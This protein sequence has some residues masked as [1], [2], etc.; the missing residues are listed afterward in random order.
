MA[1]PMGNR[2]PLDVS[3]LTARLCR[4]PR[5]WSAVHVHDRISSTNAVA[6]Q[7]SGAW[8]VVVAEH[9]SAGRGRLDRSWEA[10]AGTSLTFSATVPAPARAPGWVPLVAGLA[11][12]EAI[13]AVT[14]LTALLKWPNDVLLPADDSRKVCGILCEYRPAADP[15][16]AIVVTGIGINVSQ[17]RD[18]LPVDTGTSL[19]LAGAADTDREDLLVT[20]L[21]RFATRYAALLA[22]GA[23]ADAVRAAYRASCATLGTRVRLDRPDGRVETARAVDVDE[24]GA[25]VVDAG[26]G[27][28]RYAAG[29]VTHLRPSDAGTGLA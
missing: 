11:V 4:A 15:A 14:G 7:G 29:D 28:T 8:E 2:D 6:M 27:P 25:L 1:H 16:E 24:D 20:V 23:A 12:A 21:D 10:P 22:G 13:T 3:R 26:H 5:T 17:D 9:Q 18:E 19:A